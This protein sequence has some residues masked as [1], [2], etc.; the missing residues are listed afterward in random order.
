ML[1]G[2]I[3]KAIDNMLSDTSLSTC[4]TIFEA[5]KPAINNSDDAI[6]GYVY[7]H[8]IGSLE[9]IFN[10]LNR[11]PT[12]E[13]VSEIANAIRKRTMEIKSRIYQTKT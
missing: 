13:E 10:S 6:F 3:E 8:V 12:N 7:G 5:M 1:R 4:R 9:T 11:Q 2:A